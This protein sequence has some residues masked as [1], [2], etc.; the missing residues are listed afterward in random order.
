MLLANY[1]SDS[2][3]DS[4]TESPAPTKSAL[5]PSK[6]PPIGSGSKVK[7]RAGPVRITLDQPKS[8]HDD[9]SNGT[10]E[11]P[12]VNGESEAK[13]PKLGGLEGKGG[14]KGG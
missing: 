3:A 12:E 2:D 5:P 1:A 11:L 7:K 4:D 9:D 14:G 13:R 8:S 6:A 10:S